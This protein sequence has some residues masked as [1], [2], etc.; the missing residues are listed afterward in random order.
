MIKAEKV[1]E[2]LSA[3]KLGFKLL[4]G[5]IDR[6][7]LE[8]QI[9]HK[10]LNIYVDGLKLNIFLPLSAIDE[11]LSYRISSKKLN[12]EYIKAFNYNENKL[13]SIYSL[14]EK[15]KNFL[16]KISNIN[17]N[18]FIEF[19]KFVY[20]FTINVSELNSDMKKE[21]N[22]F[23]LRRNFSMSTFSL[24]MTCYYNSEK[25]FAK[26]FL[27]D[28]E[29]YLEVTRVKTAFYYKIISDISLRISILADRF[30]FEK[31]NVI[32]SETSMKEP[33]TI[34]NLAKLQ[35]NTNFEIEFTK[36]EINLQEQVLSHLIQ[37]FNTFKELKETKDRRRA[38]TRQ[39]FMNTIEKI[40]STYSA[41]QMCL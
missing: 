33:Q 20:N 32:F 14:L 10:K 38:A 22:E 40:I 30:R 1:N 34:K 7:E 28:K 31:S 5:S 18:F 8:G 29:K 3:S 16:F 4:S 37:I 41:M 21:T 6:I 17:I 24:T 19:E 11:M 36:F 39:K 27:E 13:N 2:I 35:S 15:M 12:A 25:D 23:F 26:K 9:F